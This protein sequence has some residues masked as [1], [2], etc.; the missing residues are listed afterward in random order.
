MS[1]R[2]RIATFCLEVLMLGKQTYGLCNGLEQC[3][4]LRWRKMA[5]FSLV[6]VAL[7]TFTIVDEVKWFVCW[8]L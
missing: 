1:I 8:F 4:H 7:G 2:C 3:S 5:L 6:V